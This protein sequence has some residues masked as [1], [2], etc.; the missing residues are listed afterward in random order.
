MRKLCFA[1]ITCFIIGLTGTSYAQVQYKSDDFSGRK[2]VTSSINDKTAK[3]FD[4]IMYN[5]VGSSDFLNLFMYKPEWHFFGD[6]VDFKFNNNTTD[7]LSV[8]AYK[9]D[10]ELTK[11]GGCTTDTTLIIPPEVITKIKTAESIALRVYFT[12][13]P[14][15]TYNVPSKMLDEW[16]EVANAEL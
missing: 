2:S 1:L 6:K 8:Q 9:T 11:G 12:N 10:S 16:K 13:Q 7:I 3:P 14:A 5:K 4:Y 15:V